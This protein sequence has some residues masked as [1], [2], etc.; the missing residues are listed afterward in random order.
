MYV[1]Y[2]FNIAH[3]YVRLWNQIHLTALK[4]IV[5]HHSYAIITKLLS[6]KIVDF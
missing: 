1:V 6:L 5:A 3:T 2:S 4:A